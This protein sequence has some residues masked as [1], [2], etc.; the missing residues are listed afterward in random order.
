MLEIPAAIQG[1]EK[2]GRAV[3]DAEKAKFALKGKI[4]PRI[5]QEK[6]GVRELSVDRLNYVELTE[7]AATQKSL[8]GRDCHGWAVL[9]VSAICQNARQLIPDPIVP[10]QLYHAYILLPEFPADQAF[11]QQKIHALELAMSAQWQPAAQ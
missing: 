5:F 4:P 6:L 10:T 2:L 1:D 11:N 9:S 3:F 8:R 7:A